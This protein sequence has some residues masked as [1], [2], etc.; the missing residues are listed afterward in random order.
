MDVADSH[1]Q[2]IPDIIIF[3]RR[4]RGIGVGQV[5][6]AGLSVR[7][8]EFVLRCVACAVRVY[9]MGKRVLVFVL[10]PVRACIV[11]KFVDLS[12]CA[13]SVQVVQS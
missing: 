2:C 1:R 5:R 7:Y 3:A 10:W 4:E 12:A 13:L 8:K 11:N 9:F 6:F